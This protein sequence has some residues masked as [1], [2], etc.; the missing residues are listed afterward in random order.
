MTEP[1]RDAKPCQSE[2]IQKHPETHSPREK[3]PSDC[4]RNDITI[5]KDIL[6]YDNYREKPHDE[7]EVAISAFRIYRAFHDE[8][9][10][11][12]YVS[13]ARK[14][15]QGI[16]QKAFREAARF[17]DNKLKKTRG[18]LFN[19]LVKLYAGEKEKI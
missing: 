1:G 7:D 19:F 11:A 15:P 18:A 9:N 3:S 14:Y 5:K 17:P 6:K 4:S 12:L 2:S 16:I 10:L 13:Y 8:G